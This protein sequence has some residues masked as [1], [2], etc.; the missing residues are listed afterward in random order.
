MHVHFR[1]PGRHE[2]KETIRTGSRAAAKGGFTAMA[3]AKEEG[4]KQGLQQGLQQGMQQG[5]YNVAKNML[6]NS[7]DLNSIKI[8]TG[9]SMEQIKKIEKE[10]KSN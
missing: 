10:I 2:Y 6:V 7:M 8:A 3:G 4:V 9:L 1:Q 5:I